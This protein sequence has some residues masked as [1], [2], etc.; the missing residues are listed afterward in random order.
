MFVAGF[1]FI[2]DCVALGFDIVLDTNVGGTISRGLL[3]NDR[4]CWG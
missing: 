2:A 4:C 1:D 3:M